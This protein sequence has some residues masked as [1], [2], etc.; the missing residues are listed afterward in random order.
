MVVTNKSEFQPLETIGQLVERV[1]SFKFQGT[2]ISNSL[3]WEINTDIIIKKCHQRLYFMHQL[4]KVRLFQEAIRLFYR[5]VIESVLTFSVIV[6]EHH[7]PRQSTAR[8]DC[9]YSSQVG[10]D[11]PSISSI[12]HAHIQHKTFRVSSDPSHPA[13][14]FFNLLPL[15]GRSQVIGIKTS[16]IKNS[17]YLTAVCTLNTWHNPV[18]IDLSSHSSGSDM[19]SN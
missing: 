2:T 6:W 4:K 17:S 7:S 15:G 1:E 10:Y 12:F 13:R 8:E 16:R 19:L 18:Y 9:A 5:A 14:C 11:L 3:K